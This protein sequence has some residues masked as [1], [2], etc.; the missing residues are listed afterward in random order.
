MKSE[1]T[2][3]IVWK[4]LA[5]ILCV[6]ATLAFNGCG[7]QTPPVD[8]GPVKIG[9]SLPLT[10]DAAVYG[11]ALKNGIELALAEHNRSASNKLAVIYEDDQY[12]AKM[13]V[14]AVQKLIQIDKVPVIIGGAGSTTAEPITSIAN[15]NKVVLLSPCATAPSLT[16]ASPY[17]FRLWPSDTYE[18]AVLAE[19][20]WNKLGIKQVAIL[21]VN[22]PYGQGITD[23]FS[24]HYQELGGTIAFSESYAQDATDFRT[25]LTK[26]K[27]A[28][29][30]WI[31]LPGYVKEVSNILKQSIELGLEVRFL[32]V[33]SLYDPNLL[34]VAGKAAEGAIFA[35]QTYDPDSTSPVIHRFVESYQTKYGA[36][37]DAFAATGYDA[38][39]VVA[40]A[41]DRASNFSGPG[42]RDSMAQTKDFDGPSGRISFDS[43]GDVIKP[44]RL[45]GVYNGDFAPFKEN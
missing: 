22:A 10:G 36:K 5:A 44:L 29:V 41:I 43:N 30:Q 34:K 33:N 11:Q 27:A 18:G 23:V 32:G 4:T 3:K 45:M 1:N 6:A 2:M 12:A 8:S 28:G 42:I 35:V 26:I 40:A 19:T 39:R 13:S 37:P 38:L 16:G 7:K 17:F 21:Y 9:A 15:Q 20:A 25:Q 24:K 14:T 31:F